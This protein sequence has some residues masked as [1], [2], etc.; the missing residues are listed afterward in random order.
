MKG[1]DVSPDYEG[2]KRAPSPSPSPS[3]KSSRPKPVRVECGPDG[4]SFVATLGGLGVKKPQ[5]RKMVQEAIGEGQNVEDHTTFL[6]YLM[7]NLHKY[8]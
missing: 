7:Q 1:L 2:E 4:D 8:R 6:A 3:P 5:A